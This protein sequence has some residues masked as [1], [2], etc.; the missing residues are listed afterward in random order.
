MFRVKLK[1]GA[2]YVSVII[3]I[4]IS[5]ILSLFILIAYYNTRTVQARASLEQLQLSLQ[6]GFEIAQSDYYSENSSNI[7]RKL[8][9]NNDS[10]K[11]K[12]MMWGCFTLIDVIAKNSHFDLQKTGLYGSLATKDTALYVTEQNRPVGLAGK[13]KF[14]GNC[15]LPKSGIKSAHIEGTSFSD[16]NSL[17]PFIKNTSSNL[18]A[19]NETFLKQIN[20]VQT[21][22][23]PF[24]D[25]LLSFIPDNSN[26][27]FH[28]KTALIQSSS[29]NLNSQTLKNNFKIIASNIIIVEKD[30][31]LENVLL[32]ARKVIFKKEFKGTVHVIATDSVITE[33]NCEFNYPSSFCVYN[34]VLKQEAQ[35]QTNLIRG[36]FFGESCKFNGGLLAVNDKSNSS[37]MMIKLNKHFELVGNLYCSNYSDVQGNL[38]GSIFCQSLLLQTPSAVYEN[39]LLSCLID[40]KK[41]S[42]QLVVPNWFSYTKPS[43][44]CAKTL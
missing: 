9:Y 16:L 39:H 41:Y 1:G 20:Q 14:N 35:K 6:S 30:C 31:Q 21:E 24:T 27:S 42:K 25:S 22:I 40:S 29:I 17:K 38:Y 18:P 8:P 28:R 32:I 43:L 44:S 3:S 13:I 33:E 19:I 26:N 34:D 37:K 10:I 4:L 2:L 15:Y 7:W 36:I 23:N 11:V 12:K 5:I